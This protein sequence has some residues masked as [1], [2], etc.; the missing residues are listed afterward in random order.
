MKINEIVLLILFFNFLYCQQNP[1]GIPPIR[2]SPKDLLKE[3]CK[4]FGENNRVRKFEECNTYTNKSLNVVCC[5]VT[6]INPDKSDYD[7]CIGISYSFANKSLSYES[8]S[9]SGKLICVENY[10]SQN[11][12]KI[13]LIVYIFS[14]IFTCL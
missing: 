1:G 4:T 11:I 7:G 12:I 5:Y 9:F 6:G 3:Q 2:N 14:F 10:S 8:K 13:P